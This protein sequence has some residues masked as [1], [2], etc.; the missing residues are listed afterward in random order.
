MRRARTSKPTV[1]RWQERYLDEGVVVL[2][3]FSSGLFRAMFAMKEI[4]NGKEIHR[5]VSA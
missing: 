4:E 1:W 5:R 3:R 2:S